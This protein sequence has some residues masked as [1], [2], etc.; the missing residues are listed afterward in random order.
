LLS[1]RMSSRLAISLIEKHEITDNLFAPEDLGVTVPL[2][3]S[4]FGAT[5]AVIIAPTESRDRLLSVLETVP[6]QLSHIA[7]TDDELLTAI[8][9]AALT[10]TSR[11][12][13]PPNRAL[14]LVSEYMSGRP[15]SVPQY[16]ESLSNLTPGEARKN[17]KEFYETSSIFTIT[18]EPAEGAEKLWAA[19]KFLLFGTL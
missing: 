8:R 14:F 4:D 9:Q 17:L 15:R 13:S 3:F 10:E 5:A 18:V 6:R 12:Q 1:N 2:T 11:L 19:I 16:L 7:V